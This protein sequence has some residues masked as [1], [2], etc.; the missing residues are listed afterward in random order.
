[1]VLKIGQFQARSQG[2][3]RGSADPPGVKKSDPP[4]Y[5]FDPPGVEVL[6]WTKQWQNVENVDQKA[7]NLLISFPQYG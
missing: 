5:K 6:P 1:M 4:E 3:S 7:G 2:G